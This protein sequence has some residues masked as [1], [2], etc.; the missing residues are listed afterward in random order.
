MEI[1]NYFA[2]D[3]QGNIMPSANCYLYLPGT[4]TLATGLVDGNGVPISNPFLASGMGQITFGAPNGV[5]DL[6]VALGARDW[7]I[8]VQC[9]DIVQAMDVMDSI[10]GSHAENPT[11]R[12]NGKP[13]EP[14]DETWNSTDKQPYW[15]SGTAWVALNSS[16]QQL[17]ER[18]SSPE[19]ADGVGIG[20]RTVYEV[21]NDEIDVLQFRTP[22]TDANRMDIAIQAGIDKVIAI[23]TT[24][25]N[26]NGL[27]RVVVGHGSWGCGATINLPI[28]VKLYSKGN[29]KLDWS[30]VDVD[31]IRIHNEFPIALQDS[32]K[33][34]AATAGCIDGSGGG[35]SLLGKGRAT[36]TKAAMRIG[37]TALGFS[38][39]RDAHMTGIV[40]T[41]WRS[42]QQFE[43]IDT[44]LCST[45]NFRFEQNQYGIRTGVGAST[46]SGE[47][48]S[49]TGGTIAGNDVGFDHNTSSFDAA[50]HNVSFDF[51]GTPIKF[52]ASSSYS[53]VQLDTNSYFEA[54]DGLAIDG[55]DIPSAGAEVAVIISGLTGLPRAGSGASGVNSPSR[56]LFNG[57]YSLSI[58]GLRMKYEKRP[59]LEDG[60]TVGPL[61]RLV[62]ARGTHRSVWNGAVTNANFINRDWD[63]QID[64][65]GTAVNAMTAWNVFATSGI[66]SAALDT[67][68]GKKVL[69][70]VSSGTSN[71]TLNSKQVVPCRAGDVLLTNC[72]FQFSAG[73]TVSSLQ[74][75]I[76]FYDYA[77]VLINTLPSNA[78]YDVAAALADSTLPNFSSGNARWMASEANRAVAPKNTASAKVRAFINN[79]NGT[80]YFSRF[81]LWAE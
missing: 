19:G 69:K 10:L 32:L 52:G 59:Y 42:A 49:W 61:V 72:A 25:G 66:T 8:K 55:V 20:I 13:L 11:T 23:A 51:S 77:G 40:A 74:M 70:I 31:G 34:A 12:N 54:W 1:K 17:E 64:P 36:S 76:E 29:V 48:M 21:L 5:Y 28:W 56:T 60:C 73:A 2:Q 71:L 47:R 9:A 3:A 80:I 14:G 39:C 18:L 75:L 43:K 46:N 26:T 65:V 63:L 44:Y 16:A 6:R 22:V 35:F 81:R 30:L 38:P 50:F 58:S 4:T 53:T 27:P 37:N 41:G 62:G 68:D 7:T 24:Q 79:P 33:F 78:N 45:S 15:W 67:F 57:N